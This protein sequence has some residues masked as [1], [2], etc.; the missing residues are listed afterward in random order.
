MCI[1]IYYIYMY[2]YMYIY[3]HPG[4]TQKA[5]RKHPRGT[6]EAPRKHSGGT[7][8]APRRHPGGTQGARRRHPGGSQEAPRKHP[9]GTQE[10]PKMHPGG[11]H[12]HQWLQRGFSAKMCQN[13]CVLQQKRSARAISR[14]RERRD[15]HRSRSLRTKM[16]GRKR[17][18]ERVPKHPVPR[19][20]ARTPTA[21]A[22]WGIFQSPEYR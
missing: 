8:E 7:Q 16:S 14:R 22:V 18:F 11:T 6:Q 5:H 17:G 19:Y 20:T 10:A 12:R 13:H 2:M 21:E 9:G 1:C 3:R 4:G 15:P